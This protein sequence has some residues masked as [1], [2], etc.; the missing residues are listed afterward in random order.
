MR[1]LW[2]KPP[3]DC[4]FI[5]EG[6]HTGAGKLS[7]FFLR[8]MYSPPNKAVTSLRSLVYRAASS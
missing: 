3:N 7:H 4:A 6:V 8:L 1:S 5:M 2:G